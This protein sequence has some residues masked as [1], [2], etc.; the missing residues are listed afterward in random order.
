MIKN[1]GYPIETCLEELKFTQRLGGFGANTEPD[2]SHP[3]YEEWVSALEKFIAS[4]KDT[5]IVNT[6]KTDIRWRYDR[7][8]NVLTLIPT[9]P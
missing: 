7:D 1:A 6:S 2:D 5:A 9:K 4:Q 8:L 3:G